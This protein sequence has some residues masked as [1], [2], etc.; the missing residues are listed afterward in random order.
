M[1]PTSKWTMVEARNAPAAIGPYSHAVVANGFVYASG[2]IPLIPETGLL[3][4]GIEA[5]T[6]QVLKNLTAVLE[7][8]GSSCEGV[9]KTTIFLTDMAHFGVVNDVYGAYFSTMKPAR[10][11]VQVGA[12]P[13]GALIEIEAV[14]LV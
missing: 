10:S 4:E 1:G 13:K 6:H 9:V 2:Q 3:A 8:A 7:A 5:Q 14:A 12:L 11:T